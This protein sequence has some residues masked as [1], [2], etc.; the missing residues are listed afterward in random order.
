MVRKNADYERLAEFAQSHANPNR[1]R[2]P[3]NYPGYWGKRK[4]AYMKWKLKHDI[5]ALMGP[6]P[7]VICILSLD[8]THAGGHHWYIARSE[9]FP[10]PVVIIERI[11]LGKPRKGFYLFPDEDCK[12]RVLAAMQGG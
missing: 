10:F 9:I 8:H 11:P 7:R 4:F 1:Y 6:Y 12:K 2:T 5:K 3:S